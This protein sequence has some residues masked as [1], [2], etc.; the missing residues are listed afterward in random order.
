MPKLLFVTDS[1]DADVGGFLRVSLLR[2]HFERDG[3]ETDHVARIPASMYRFANIP[4]RA[5]ARVFATGAGRVARETAEATGRMREAHI[6]KRAEDADVVLLQKVPSADLVVA[7]RRKTRAKIVYDFGN[8]VW[9]PRANFAGGRFEEIVRAAHGLT[10]DNP[11]TAA[12]VRVRNPNV[13]VVPDPPQVE[14]FDQ[15]RGQVRRDPDKVVLG[16][17][18]IPGT[19]FN[20]YAAWE[21]IERAAAKSDAIELRILGSGHLPMLLPRFERI[22]WSTL[23]SYDQATMIREVLQMDVGL[24]PMFDVEDSTTRGVLKACVYM[25]GEAAVIASPRGQA[26]DLIQHGRNGLLAASSEDWF[27]AIMTLADDPAGRRRIAAAGLQTIRDGFTVQHAY[28]IMASAIQ[29][30][31]AS[32]GA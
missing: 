21:G 22:R 30:T 32:A 9:L 16:W 7:L 5:M 10:T 29:A 18:G 12:W 14:A 13:H 2:P 28:K 23:P 1:G 4:G 31:L 17:V 15:M 8:A 24:F 27:R 11:Y 6:V 3:W 26:V 19:L 25:A 20:L